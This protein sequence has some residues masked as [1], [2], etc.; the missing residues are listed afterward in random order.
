MN[1]P[2]HIVS[3]SGLIE[4]D[5]GKIL[6]LLSPDRGWEIPGG[7]VEEGE[8]LTDALKREVKEETGIYI[9]VGNLKV[10]YSNVTKRVQPD[11]VSSIGSIVNFGFTGK[12]ISGE[13]TT[14]EESLEVA[15]SDREKVLDLIG[16]DFMRDRVKSMLSSEEKIIY[17][18]FTREPYILHEVQYI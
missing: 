2:V 4:N 13:L 11:G 16:K 3:V 5:E 6:M 10:V 18:V 7:Q 12:A 15:W 14:S 9:E 1:Y 8:S 17:G